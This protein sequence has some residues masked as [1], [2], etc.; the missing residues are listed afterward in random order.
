MKKYQWL[1]LLVCCALLQGCVVL[2]AGAG[3][4]GG[5]SVANDNRSFQTMT[6]DQNIEFTASS[7][8]KASPTLN[9]NTHI[10]VVSFDHVVLIAGQ[11]P[12]NSI[13]QR[14][15][16]LVEALPKVSRVYNELEIAPPTSM[17]I[18]SNDTWITTKVKSQMIA[19]KDLNSGQIK[20]VTENGTVF[21]MGIVTPRQSRLAADVAR[22]VDGVRKVVTLFEYT[23]QH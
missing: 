11:V 16:A 22:Q 14:V 7:E 18:R 13:R 8:I 12:G 2:A 4:A 19:A 5:A 17:L 21:L 3:V 10:T 20:V 1:V 9:Y 6:D 15:S 23:Y